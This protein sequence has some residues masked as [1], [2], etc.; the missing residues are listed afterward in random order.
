MITC[1]DTYAFVEGGQGGK[2]I[3]AAVCCARSLMVVIDV[4]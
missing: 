1:V 3:V 4:S 2:I